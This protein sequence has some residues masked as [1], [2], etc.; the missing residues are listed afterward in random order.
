METTDFWKWRHMQNMITVGLWFSASS[1]KHKASTEPSK[2]QQLPQHV[3][4]KVCTRAIPCFYKHGLLPSG[5]RCYRFH[6][7]CLR[8]QNNLTSPPGTRPPIPSSEGASL[9]LRFFASCSLQKLASVFSCF[10]LFDV[11]WFLL[12]VQFMALP[13]QFMALALCSLFI[14]TVLPQG[15]HPLHANN[16]KPLT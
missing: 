16:T 12:P 4:L 15:L 1:Q 14:S 6:A 10:L 13:L 5:M 9:S 3:Y 11:L 2:F 8:L 7:E